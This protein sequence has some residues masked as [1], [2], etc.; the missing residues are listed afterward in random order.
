MSS[1]GFGLNRAGIAARRHEEPEN[2]E[3]WLVFHKADFIPCCLLFCG[4]VLIRRSTMVN[5]RCCRENPGRRISI[6][7]SGLWILIQIGEEKYPRVLARSDGEGHGGDT[8]E[9]APGPMPACRTSPE[10]DGSR[11]LAKL[12]SAG[13]SGSAAGNEPVDRDRAHSITLRSVCCI[14]SRRDAFCHWMPGSI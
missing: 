8:G 12:I 9:G 13:D 4:H 6:N 3:R 11:P 2:H 14:P 5:T 1:E 10:S 7:R